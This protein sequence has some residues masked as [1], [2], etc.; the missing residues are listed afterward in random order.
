M[1]MD[2][3]AEDNYKSFMRAMERATMIISKQILKEIEDLEHRLSQKA[4]DR[5]LT[6]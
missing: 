5:A 2:S 6:S 4:Q 3:V 1:S